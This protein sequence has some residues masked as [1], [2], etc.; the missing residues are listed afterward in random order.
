MT[1]VNEKPPED[2]DAVAAATA[3]D[4]VIALLN[5]QELL[6]LLSHRLFAAIWL[7]LLIFLVLVFWSRSYLFLLLL[8]G[9]QLGRYLLT[10]LFHRL[11]WVKHTARFCDGTKKT[12]YEHHE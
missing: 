6:G 9:F 10:F 2:S 8:L 3:N 1:P 7:L 12:W 5:I 11:A 4:E